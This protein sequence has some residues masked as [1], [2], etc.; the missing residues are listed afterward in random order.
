MWY[1]L[2]ERAVKVLGMCLRLVRSA[3]MKTLLVVEKSLKLLCATLRHYVM[4]LWPTGACCAALAFGWISLAEV[5]NSQSGLAVSAMV[6]W[7][8][9]SL[10]VHFFVSVV[11]MLRFGSPRDQN[12]RNLVR[13]R[14][15]G[16]S[17][18]KRLVICFVSQGIQEPVLKSSVER[19]ISLCRDFAVN[20]EIEVVVD[21]KVP[22]DNFFAENGCTIVVVPPLYVTTRGSQ[23]KARSLCYAAQQRAKRLES[24]DSTWVLHCDEDTL[25]TASAI[26]GI[27]E[28][29]RAP[30]SEVV[31]G[32]GEIKYNAIPARVSDI[33]AF[34][35]CHR[36]G[37]D[38]GRFR[39]QFAS[40]GAALFGMHGSFLLVPAELER[41]IGFDFGPQGSITEDIYFALR[42]R[43]SGVACRWIEG[44]VREQSPRDSQN[45]LRQRA[46]WIHGLLNSCL[47][48]S[49]CWKRRTLL[50]IYLAMWRTTIISGLVLT[51]LMG[52]TGAA[53]SI[54]SLWSLSMVVIGTNSWVGALRNVEEDAPP[55]SWRVVVR[56][57]V[58]VL[59]I[60]IVCLFET[61]AVVLGILSRPRE[62]FV[63]QK[64]L[65]AAYVER[66]VA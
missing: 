32:A 35:D 60:P 40:W 39:L 55:G 41:Q 58:A 6:L 42:L 22:Q 63:V 29:L 56:L 1:D 49:F 20:F 26:A 7:L 4:V 64:M 61:I 33:Y 16:W 62:F 11:G 38:I 15:E 47:D 10:A 65:P 18:Q 9:L 17:Q 59:L 45:F 5:W 36:T 24:L 21:T 46:R 30:D 53:P 3:T 2:R 51:I 23:F 50:L 54:V 37:E 66:G 44:Y 19:A 27:N 31:C 14:S 8:V 48:Q 52:V 34:M 57:I 43:E 28:H 12:A 25:L 13:L